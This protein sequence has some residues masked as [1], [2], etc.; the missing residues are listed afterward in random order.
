V[1]GPGYAAPQGR[2]NS[3]MAE[4]SK[5]PDG[6]VEHSFQMPIHHL[7]ILMLSTAVTVSAMAIVLSSVF[8]H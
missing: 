6:Y 5:I 7:V 2:P 4:S 8:A 3:E 1:T